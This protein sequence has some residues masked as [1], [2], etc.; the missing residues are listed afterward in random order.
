M[1]ETLQDCPSTHGKEIKDKVLVKDKRIKPRVIGTG[2]GVIKGLEQELG[3]RL[4]VEDVVKDDPDQ[5]FYVRISGPGLDEVC[6]WVRP[7]GY[8]FVRSGFSGGKLQVG[9]GC[10]I[11]ATLGGS[12]WSS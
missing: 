9:W 5:G 7:C 10:Q 6:R 3:C 11:I 8:S 1:V 2:G 4:R 12:F